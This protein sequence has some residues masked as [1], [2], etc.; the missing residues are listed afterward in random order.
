M[1]V[2]C[3]NAQ[4][5]LSIDYDYSILPRL[6]MVHVIMMRVGSC[7]QVAPSGKAKTF[8]SPRTSCTLPF[9]RRNLRQRGETHTER[10]E[11]LD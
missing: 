9:E 8:C 1:L 6:N 11:L 3:V 4:R 10:E 2:S 5:T 7:F